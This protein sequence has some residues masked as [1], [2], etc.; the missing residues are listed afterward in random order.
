MNS[1]RSQ[2]FLI[3]F[4]FLFYSRSSSLSILKAASLVSASFGRREL[5]VIKASPPKPVQWPGKKRTNAIELQE[6][7]EGIRWN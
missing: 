6:T 3:S 2:L 1:F 4:P 5:L 7:E